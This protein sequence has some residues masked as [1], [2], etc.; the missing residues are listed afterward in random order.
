MYVNKKF[1]YENQKCVK[2]P[3]AKPRVNYFWLKIQLAK[4]SAKG[5]KLTIIG[6]TLDAHGVGWV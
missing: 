3:H 4:K 5:N 6:C 1:I 2:P